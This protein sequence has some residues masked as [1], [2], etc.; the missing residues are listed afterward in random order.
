MSIITK[1]QF[2][3][4]YGREMSEG[5]FAIAYEIFSEAQMPL[6]EFVADYRNR[7]L[8][9]SAIITALRDRLAA[10]HIEIASVEHTL[11][12]TRES[13]AKAVAVT[14]CPGSDLRKLAV[15]LV[16]ER[17]YLLAKLDST[18][19]LDAADRKDLI[20]MLRSGDVDGF[21]D[22]PFINEL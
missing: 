2:E 15:E 18:S 17:S 13:V 22:N 11:F 3:A 19:S 6:D 7:D 10:L 21:A 20:M 12:K 4:A 14:S 16:G 1:E 9:D 5:E 8:A